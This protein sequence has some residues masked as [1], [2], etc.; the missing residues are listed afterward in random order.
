MEQSRRVRPRGIDH[1]VIAV[2][3]LEKARAAY[4]RLG[5]TVTPEAVHP[6]GT[7]NSLV[8]LDGSFLEL[9]AINDAATIP[10]AREG[11]FSFPAF[12][13][14]FLE[15]QEGLSMLV[16]KSVD[17]NLDHAA[18]AGHRLPTYAPFQFERT[19]RAPDGTERKVAFTLA[20]TSEPRLR[21]AGFFTCRHH[22]P[23]N[24]WRAEYQRHANGAR[25]IASAVMVTR[26][27][28]DFHEFLTYFT[29]VHDMKSTSLGIDFDLGD[30]S[31]VE[32][33]SPPGFH[34]LFGGDSGPD[35]RRFLACRVGVAD[36]AGT[37]SFLE[38]NRVAFAERPEGLVVPPK[39]AGGV[40][41]AF[42]PQ[43]PRL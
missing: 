5:F 31:H 33:L 41:I 36:I 25:T 28:A 40:T 35:P 15:R 24:F 13:R 18:F 27:P 29:G 4:R 23:E 3:D 43:V 22:F 37:R 30:G 32:V 7:K 9:L 19:A 2:R 8:Q 39:E 11:F 34:G 14:D 6:F 17:P 38:A 26:D 20:F 42:S 1:L 16:L 10:P 21:D 12:N